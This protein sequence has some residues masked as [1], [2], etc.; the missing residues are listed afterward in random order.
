[1]M[2]IQRFYGIMGYYPMTFLKGALYTDYDYKVWVVIKSLMERDKLNSYSKYYFY[3]SYRNIESELRKFIKVNKAD[4]LENEI[5]YL[6]KLI[7]LTQTI[8]R[9]TLDCGSREFPST[10]I[11]LSTSNLQ[12]FLTEYGQTHELKSDP[13]VLMLENEEYLKLAEK[14]WPDVEKKLNEN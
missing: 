1:M 12:R 9:F 10:F 8:K 14:L 2:K 4:L 7:N 5:L 13:M 6:R 11:E 3:L